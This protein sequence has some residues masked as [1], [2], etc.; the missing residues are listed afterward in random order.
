MQVQGAM[1]Q[2]KLHQRPKARHRYRNCPLDHADEFTLYN[3]HAFSPIAYLIFWC[4]LHC[5]HC[6]HRS[7]WLA[8]HDS[9]VFLS[10]ILLLYL[11]TLLFSFDAKSDFNIITLAASA[12]E[13][14]RSEQLCH[15]INILIKVHLHQY[16]DIAIWSTMSHHQNFEFIFINITTLPL[17]IW[18]IRRYCAASL[19]AVCDKSSVSRHSWEKAEKQKWQ[20]NI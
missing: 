1:P 19:F 11:P 17:I 13:S 14:S 16:H 10:G 4:C 9:A 12:S 8:N 5:F 15:I 3:F 20:L 6:F 18:F 7:N 2:S